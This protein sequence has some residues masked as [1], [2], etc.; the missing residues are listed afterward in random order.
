MRPTA[1]LARPCRRAVVITEI[2][3][4]GAEVCSR[5]TKACETLVQGVSDQWARP[6]RTQAPGAPRHPQRCQG[7]TFLIS[8]VGRS[9]QDAGPTLD[10]RGRSCNWT[11]IPSKTTQGEARPRVCSCLL[12]VGSN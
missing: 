9:C 4:L 1:I 5:Q 11:S 7:E 12:E 2:P 10:L 6:Q 3:R 8:Q